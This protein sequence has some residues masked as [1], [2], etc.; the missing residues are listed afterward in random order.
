M[1]VKLLLARIFV[2]IENVIGRL[3]P[4]RDADPAITPYLGYA[5]PTEVIV[6]GRVLN[7][8]AERAMRPDQS[9]FANFRAMISLF[10]TD[11]IA[12]VRLSAGGQEQQS[13]EEGYFSFHLPIKDWPRGVVPV[14][15]GERSWDCP[16]MIP[17]PGATHGVISDVDDTLIKTGAYS[18]WRNVW[19]SLTGNTATREVFLDAVRLMKRL[20][21]GGN[22]IYFVSSSPWNFY[23]FLRDVLGRT[24]MPVGPMFLRDYGISENQFITGTHGD[25]KGQAIDTILQA[26][27]DLMFVLVGDTGQHDAHVYAEAAK[28]HPG[29]IARVILRQAGPALDSES[30]AILQDLG[31][32]VHVGPNY[33]DMEI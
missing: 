3:L 30:I 21:E 32:P 4:R 24:D 17:Q 9:A 1:N 6:R 15:I 14:A 11:E 18:L 13:D 27:P 2:R 5:T 19:T 23:S 10:R 12:G 16:V 29:R 22:P 8:K 26:N 25:H 20:T 33:D 31:I 28:R 7:L